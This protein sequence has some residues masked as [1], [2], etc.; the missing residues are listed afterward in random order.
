MKKPKWITKV[1]GKFKSIQSTMLVSFSAL[2]VL[3]MLI[4]M[5]IAMRY[6]SDTI[7]ENTINY[8]TQIIQQVNYDIDTYI[9]YME[10]ISSV[11]A[12]SSD[13]PRYLF[14]PNQTEETK[15]AEKSRILTQFQTI[16]ES[17]QDIYNVAAV[18]Q[19][20]RYIINQ[21]EDKLTS[22]IDIQSLDWYQAAMESKNGIAVS[23]SHVQNAIQ[24]SYKWVITLS[25]ALVNNQT[26]EREGIFFVDLNYSAISDLCNNNSMK[27]KG[28]IFVLDNEGNIIYHP[29]QQLMYGGLKTEN[30]DAIMKCKDTSLIIKEGGE[31]KLYTI[32][33]SKKTG[34]RVVGAAYTSDLLKNNEQAQMWYLLVASILLLAVIGISTIISREITKPI[35]SLR[36]SMRKVQKGQFDTHVDVTTENEIGSLGKSF[37]LMTSEIQALMEQNVYEQK[38]KRKSELKALQAQI[39]PH[40]L[41][42]TL[43]S[44]IWMSEAGENE[45]VVEMTSALAHLLRQSISNDQEEIELEKEI[46]YVK[47]YLTIQKMRYKDK[48]EYFTY[49]DPRVSHVRI[50]KLVLQPLVENAIYHGI[51]YKETKGC[52]KI[53]ARQEEKNVIIVVEDDGIGMDEE[54][55]EHIFDEEKKEKKHNGVGVPNVQKRI[56]LQYGP[57]YGIR[58]ESMKGV[59][60]KA[61]VSIPIDGGHTDEK[62]DW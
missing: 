8:M 10:N 32:S 62:M 54:T 45:E 31:S 59:G 28:Y 34:W 55:L 52:L 12:K 14:E 50:I 24:S 51:K 15:E 1:F 46:E 43:D 2:M 27:D 25:R 58:Y 7:Y 3:A 57:E 48:L 9:E 36:D 21:G 18:A 13:V 44:I 19:N 6:T 47:N 23:S 61:I 49:I 42:N 38:Q 56:R 26:G 33:K 40:F 41:Y 30:I 4:F 5:L 53:Y 22:Y 37:N 29:K 39:N 20:G 11:I 16:M 60:T 17:R 35:R